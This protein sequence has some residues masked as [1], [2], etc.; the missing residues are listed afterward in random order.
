M[1]KDEAERLLHESRAKIDS[2]DRKLVDLL[3]DRTRMVQDIGR[4]K[5]A[6][7]MQVVE[8]K[9]EAS[10]Y[11]NVRLHNHGPIPDEAVERIFRQII[12]EMRALQGMKSSAAE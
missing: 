4:A 5:E 3:N 10:V 8:P 11:R 7:G 1:T 2:C 6:M 9:R 12:E